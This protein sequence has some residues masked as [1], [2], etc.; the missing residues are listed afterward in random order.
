MF[1]S[2]GCSAAE[3]K[4]FSLLEKRKEGEATADLVTPS[5]EAMMDPIA[6]VDPCAQAFFEL[7]EKVRTVGHLSSRVIQA[8]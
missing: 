1:R 6:L 8:S 7:Q 2:P 3:A 5:L 4:I